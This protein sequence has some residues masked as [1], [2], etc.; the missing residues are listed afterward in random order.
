MPATTLPC[1]FTDADNTLWDTNAIYAAAQT[2]L[3]QGVS[4]AT[5]TLP[6][7]TG[8]LALVRHFDQQLA[9]SHPLGFR[10]PPQ[11]LIDKLCFAISGRDP[12]SFNKKL[13]ADALDQY[14]ADLEEPPQ[15]RRGVATGL[16]ILHDV[17]IPVIIVSEGS[18]RAIDINIYHHNLSAHF[19]S[20]VTC[21]KSPAIYLTLIEK[22]G[23]RSTAFS[24]GDQLDRDI[25][26]AKKAGM[27]TAYFP[28]DFKPHWHNDSLQT[29]A[30]YTINDYTE[31][32]AITDIHYLRCCA[33]KTP[34]S[35]VKD[36]TPRAN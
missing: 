30:D 11:L 10:Y 19:A 20:I 1:V 2:Q 13:I 14:I 29:Y 34:S 35:I 18:R 32:L 3:V 15:L 5:E 31:I 28:S 9:K 17:D 12:S 24:V 16:Q 27:T 23:C 8:E 6:P 4:Q 26:F 7:S 21:I 25:E 36:R 22:I 33:P